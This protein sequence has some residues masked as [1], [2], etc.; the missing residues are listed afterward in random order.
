MRY[1]EHRDRIIAG[2][3][4]SQLKF[5]QPTADAPNDLTV[6]YK[7][8][9]PSEIF[10][11]DFSAD[12]NHFALG[13]ND[14]SLIIKSKSIEKVVEVDEEQKIFDA[15]EPELISTSKNYKY[16]FR[17]QYV[18]RADPDDIQTTEMTK[19]R[20]L[21]PYEQK[22]K[23]FEYKA[24]L[25]NALETRNPEVVLSLIEELVEREGLYIA[26]GNRSE[27]EL[28]Q[29][30]EFLIWK[31]PDYRYSQVLTE[32]ARITIDMYAS[33]IGLSPT[34]DNKLLKELSKTLDEQIE[35]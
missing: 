30:V 13:L 31:L 10:A 11:M 12:G 17:G 18:V 24:A 8:K 6:A 3:L 26:I 21:Q 34:V 5:F 20:R 32:V 14:G 35:L 25:N 33:V 16:F 7:I 4:D 9:V 27:Q 1:D 19:K 23:R 29:L 2:G 22:L 28:V 15:L